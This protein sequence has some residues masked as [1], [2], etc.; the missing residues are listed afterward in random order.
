MRDATGAQCVIV[1]RSTGAGSTSVFRK[2]LCSLV[3][4]REI[5]RCAMILSLYV[6]GVLYVCSNVLERAIVLKRAGA[7]TF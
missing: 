1:R 4:R 3:N 2:S 7:V 6:M 5:V